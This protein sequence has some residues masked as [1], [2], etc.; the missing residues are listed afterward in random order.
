MRQGRGESPEGLSHPE[1]C[2]FRNWSTSAWGARESQGGLCLSEGA[3]VLAT[4]ALGLGVSGLL[5]GCSR[6]SA[7][8]PAYKHLPHLLTYSSGKPLRPS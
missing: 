4:H 3:G 8:S 5:Q 2:H 6:S 1:D 7:C